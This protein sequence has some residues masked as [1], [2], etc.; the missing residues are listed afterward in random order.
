MKYLAANA[1]V[2]I[3]EDILK[4]SGGEKYQ[5]V[6]KSSVEICKVHAEVETGFLCEI[7]TREEGFNSFQIPSRRHYGGRRRRGARRCFLP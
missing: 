6:A 5:R 4:L 7:A 1:A 2:H 3:S